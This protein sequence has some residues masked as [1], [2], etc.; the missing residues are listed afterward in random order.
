M[1]QTWK[2]KVK[3]RHL[4][5]TTKGFTEDFLGLT[6]TWERCSVLIL[7]FTIILHIITMCFIGI[8][9][10]SATNNLNIINFFHNWTRTKLFTDFE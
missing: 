7:Y 2:I 10:L 4:K 3:K 6:H 8:L 5:I 9:I 1:T